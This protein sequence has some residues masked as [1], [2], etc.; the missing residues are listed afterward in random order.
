MGSAGNERQLF[1]PVTLG[2]IELK[3]RFVKAATFEGMSPDNVVSKTLVEFHRKMAAGGV[4]MT[5]VSYIAVSP[6]GMGAPA[7]IYIHDAAADGLAHI[8]DVVHSEGARIAAQIGHAGAVGAL[9]GKK[10]MGP[11]TRRTMMGDKVQAMSIGEIDEVV[12]QF[13]AAGA[14]LRAAG[15][16]S[17][18]LHLGHHYLL[19]S[20]LSPK[21]NKRTDEYG[22]SLDDRARL[23]IR[24]LQA[25]RAAIGP[26]MALTA[27]MNMRDGVRGGLEIDDSIGLAQRFEATGTLDAFEFSAGGS[28]QNQM[29][30]FRGD[31]PRD[32]FMQLVPPKFKLGFKLF[33]RWIL[34]A[35][36]YEPGYFMA[37]A[38]RFRVNLRTPIVYLGGVSDL[39]TAQAAVD[40][41]F[42]YVAL[43]RGL[44]REPDLIN[45]WQD[46]SSTT[47]TCIQCNKC[48]L[49]IY[50]GT[51][52]VLDHP[53]PLQIEALDL[54]G[55]ARG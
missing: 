46:G 6:N 35:Y 30:M 14:M 38:K 21:W 22:G 31:A 48:M 8:A 13:A 23:P 54:G 9:P 41:G 15:F 16:D 45:R 20:F 37:M 12:E 27:K 47:S 25:V 34:P 55:T 4:S 11:S 7:E 19:S 3:N 43:G 26:D 2:P 32:E 33:G 39:A 18:E 24:V 5:T 49:S 1:E 17:M 10:I 29:Y 44:V 28:Q 52:C 50:T 40:A 42:D 53:E 36:P 51:R